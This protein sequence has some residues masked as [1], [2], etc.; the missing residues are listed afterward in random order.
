MVPRLSILPLDLKFNAYNFAEFQKL[1]DICQE[2]GLC[3]RFSP[4]IVFIEE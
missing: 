4:Q 1:K 3:L 2:E